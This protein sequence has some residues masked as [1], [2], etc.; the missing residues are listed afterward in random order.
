MATNYSEQLAELLSEIR[1]AQNNIDRH[2]VAVEKLTTMFVSHMEK[3]SV[4]NNKLVIFE[5]NQI[6]LEKAVEGLNKL[7]VDG[8]HKEDGLVKQLNDLKRGFEDSA[9]KAKEEKE[10]SRQRGMQRDADRIIASEKKD[11]AFNRK[12]LVLM[13]V[14]SILA[15]IIP[16]LVTILIYQL[17]KN[18]IQNPIKIEAK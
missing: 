18:P 8:N 2:S 11:K 10:E 13:A 9:K 16:T 4:L 6:R 5:Q 1:V 17:D 3:D 7:L 14:I 12:M 15:F